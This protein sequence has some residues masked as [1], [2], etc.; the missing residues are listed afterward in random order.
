MVSVFPV[1]YRGNSFFKKAFHGRE[2]TN[3]KE[4]LWEKF[5]TGE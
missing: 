5:Y 3:F 2:G 1:K 4:N